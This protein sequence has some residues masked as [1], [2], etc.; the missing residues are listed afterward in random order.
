[1]LSIGRKVYLSTK[2]GNLV[3]SQRRGYTCVGRILS[4]DKKM[5]FVKLNKKIKV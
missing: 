4:V 2:T 5:G 1:M 3:L